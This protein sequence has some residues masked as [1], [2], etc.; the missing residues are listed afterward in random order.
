MIHI[1]DTVLT[2]PLNVSTTASAA[3]LT[4]FLGAVN[5]TG[6]TETLDTSSDI[7]I[8]A[9][10]NSAFQNIASGLGNLST[11]DLTGIL[12]YHVLNGTIA[13]SS[14]LSNATVPT[15]GGGNLTITIANGTAFV[16]SAR[17][18]NADILISGGVLH[19][20]DSVL[21]PNNTV[22]ANGTEGTT[23]VA[24]FSGASSEA[25]VP[26]TSGVPTPT[27]TIEVLVTSTEQV[28]ASYTPTGGAGAGGVGAASSGTSSAGAAPTGVIGAAALFGGAA[29]L[30]NL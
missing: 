20:I 29:F 21:N 18:I 7:T 4:A 11:A 19:I 22:A 3:N 27:T 5:A 24:A 30:A 13:Y 26:Y 25:T 17:V 1:I 10:S 14:T 16:N 8:F 15:L 6:L 2:V 28:V 23:P 9:P 12:A